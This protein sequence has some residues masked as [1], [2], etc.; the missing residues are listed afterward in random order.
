MNIAHKTKANH[1]QTVSYDVDIYAEHSTT[2][3]KTATQ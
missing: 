1:R 2:I 3:A